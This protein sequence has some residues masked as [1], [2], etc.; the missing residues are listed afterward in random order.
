M[1]AEQWERLND[2]FEQALDHPHDGRREFVDQA[3]RENPDLGEKLSA[4]LAADAVDDE[5]ILPLQPALYEAGPRRDGWPTSVGAVRGDVSDDELIGQRLDSWL[6]ERRIGSGGMGD[7]Y[8]ASR[9]DATF[10][11]IV[12]IKVL[13]RGLDTEEL[14]RRFDVERKV[15]GALDHP[16]IARLID[17]GSVAD[18]RPYLLVE[19]VEGLP[20]D[21]YCSQNALAL[22]AVLRL[23]REICAAV[24]HA[25][26]HLVLHCDLK[27][28][29]ILV[30]AGSS[31]K[32]L[33]FGIAK[34]LDEQ[35]T[36]LTRT[37]TQ[38]PMTL[39]YS[40]PE[41]IE[42]GALSTAS[43]VYSLG[44]VL[45]EL[46]T[47]RSPYRYDTRAELHRAVSEQLPTRPSTKLSPGPEVTQRR[48]TLSFRQQDISPELDTIVLTA[49]RKDPGERYG[50]VEQFSEDIRRQLEGLPIR[51]R[52]A[53]LGYVA[54]KFVGRH[55]WT[56]AAAFITLASLILGLLGLFWKAEEIA[57]QRDRAVSARTEADDAR[58]A[59]GLALAD[60]RWAREESEKARADSDRSRDAADQARQQAESVIAFLENVL[61]S[62]GPDRLGRRGSLLEVLADT[63]RTVGERFS[64]EPLVEA[65]VRTVL[66]RTWLAL[67]RFDEAQQQL[68][69][70]LAQREARLA[71]DH[72]DVAESLDAL[73]QLRYARQDLAGALS[74]F[75]R[76]L[77]LSRAS[78]GGDRLQ[79]AMALNNMGAVLNA[80]GE[81]VRAEECLRDALATRR[82][83][84]DDADPLIAE[85]LVNLAAS[86]RA[87]QALTEAEEVLRESLSLRRQSLGPEH[88]LVS[89][90]LSNLAV[91]LMQRGELD[92]A[93]RLLEEA[94]AIQRQ[95]LGDDHPDLATDLSNLGSL[96]QLRGDLQAA[97]QAL[98]ECVAIRQ[99]SFDAEHFLITS[100]EVRHGIV[101]VVL[102]RAAESKPLLV[103]GAERFVAAVGPR[104]QQ[105]RTVMEATAR[106]YEATGRP[107]D[108]RIWRDR[109]AKGAVQG[110]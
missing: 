107:G 45:Y 63:T 96:H 21:R 66:G 49:L 55:R 28:A 103:P 65:T 8:L 36:S 10:D 27:P 34:L 1:H 42:G 60:A 98:R 15:L 86:L 91:V 48:C 108:A 20:V 84:L 53:T 110:P 19:H 9:A 82:A 76:T 41:L 46:V 39:E 97:E 5:F 68:E 95:V 57:V 33:D 93:A 6:I 94:V 58:R 69:T 52:P 70:G 81:H 56:T 74:L 106:M 2:L 87:R 18:G 104:D 83:L 38:R 75:E 17:A 109:L 47:G 23:F 14:L 89:Q 50:S 37:G 13:K 92:E 43:D 35:A 105:A 7:V 12:A 88:P 67:G 54:R 80:Q 79:T 59:M 40:S 72:P 24:E 78:A 71:Q 11:K 99:R 25:H 31:P 100:A 22:E 101:L 51:A 3:C 4:M 102:G 29:N 73:G 32:L 16:G 44:V 62:A 77:A 90:N 64:Q 85:T 26:G 61:S 30:G